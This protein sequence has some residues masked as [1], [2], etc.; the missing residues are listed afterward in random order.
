MTPSQETIGEF[1][2]AKEIMEAKKPADWLFWMFL[3]GYKCGL[4]F[5]SRKHDEVYGERE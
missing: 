4:R 2:A 1:K 5:A 3:Q